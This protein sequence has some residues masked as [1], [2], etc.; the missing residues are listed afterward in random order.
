MIQHRKSVVVPLPVEDEWPHAPGADW[1]WQESVVLCFQDVRQRVGGFIRIGHH[2]NRATGNLMFGIVTPDG[3]YNRSRQD[4]AMRDGDR[5]ATGFALDGFIEAT[6]DEASSRWRAADGDC[7]VD[8]QV[9]IVHPLYDT[10]ALSGLTGG[11]RDNFAASHTEVA[12]TVTGHV[13]I[14]DQTWVVDGY[15]YRDHSWGVRR[16]D[17]PES[18][19]SNLCWLVGSFGPD[20]VFEVCEIITAAGKTQSIGYVIKDGVFDLPTATDLCFTVEL[21]GISMRGGRCAFT[22]EKLGDFEFVIDGFGNV[23][24][25]ME[26]RYLECGM[27]GVVHW[28]GRTGGVHMSSMF[29]AR[30]GSAVPP[31]LFGAVRG[32]GAYRRASFRETLDRSS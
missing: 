31:R 10:W 8:L 15:A 32:N 21:D 6:F 5:S 14:G 1:D 26:E 11:F 4:V 22:T 27:P 7:V 28:N 19:L 24:L 23:L 12:G 3:G 25:G 13:R 30:A 17:A 18:A 16:L 29:N 9:V 20:F 2:P